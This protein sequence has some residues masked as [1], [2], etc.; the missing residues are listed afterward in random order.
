MK[1]K[2]IHIVLDLNSILDLHSTPE[3]ESG[4]FK[5]SKKECEDFVNNQPN[6]SLYKII[7]I[8]NQFSLS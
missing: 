8:T 2:E 3:E 5:G 6:P 1:L 4:H 7:P